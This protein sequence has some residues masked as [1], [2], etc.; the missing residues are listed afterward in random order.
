MS[1]T[2]STFHNLFY[3]KIVIHKQNLF[4]FN[5]PFKR[6]LRITSLKILLTFI[7]SLVSFHSIRPHSFHPSDV[8]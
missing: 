2:K 5:R 4:T 7:V 8:T 6:G 3:N 1:K